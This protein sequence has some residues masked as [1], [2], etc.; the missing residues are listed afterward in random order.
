MWGTSGV[1]A[2]RMASLMNTSGFS[3]KTYWNG[4]E[5]GRAPPTGSRRSR[6]ASSGPSTT[7]KSRPAEARLDARAQG[8]AEG[9]GEQAAQQRPAGSSS[10]P[11]RVH[12]HAGHLVHEQ[13]H[14]G[15][16]DEARARPRGCAPATIFS[17]ATAD[18][19]R[20]GPAGAR[21]PR[22]CP[23][24]S[25][26]ERHQHALHAGH[27]HG[28]RHEAGHHHGAEL[29]GHEAAGA[30]GCCRT[31]ARPGWAGSA[32]PSGAGGALR[33]ATSRSRRSR[34]RKAVTRAA[35]SR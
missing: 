26:G 27:Q 7:A 30:A 8:Q 4:P 18:H 31:R 32:W 28:D 29:V 15:Q 5:H 17:S 13:H 6:T 9:G 11:A 22:G 25:V 16:G 24:R 34:A 12:R 2:R 19:R 20:W 33:D 21:P 14:R 35:P 10:Q 1:T 23:T 3:R